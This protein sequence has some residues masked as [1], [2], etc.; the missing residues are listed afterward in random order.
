MPTP[1]H[2]DGRRLKVLVIGG[3]D[4]Q[5][6]IM[7]TIFRHLGHELIGDRGL[8][9]MHDGTMPGVNAGHISGMMA[10]ALFAE[11]RPDLVVLDL[12][13]PDS[14]GYDT[15]VALRRMEDPRWVPIWCLA[16]YGSRADNE[17][18]ALERGADVLLPRPIHLPLLK[19]HLAQVGRFLVR[20]GQFERRREYLQDY[21]ESAESEIK[22]ARN[23]MDR[24]LRTQTDYASVMQSWIAPAFKFSGDAMVAE[25]SPD[26]SLKLLLADGV[27]HGL[28][29]ALNVL[30]VCR[31]FQSMAQK[32]F[33]LAAMVVELNHTIRRDLPSH[34]FVAATLVNVNAN[35]GIIEVWNGGNPACF[36]IDALGDVAETWTSNHLPLGVVDSD[37]LDPRPEVRALET[38]GQLVLYSDGAIEALDESG[39]AFGEAALLQ[40]LAEAPPGVRLEA[41][42]F[43]VVEHLA[44]RAANDDVTLALLDCNAEFRQARTRR[45]E[46]EAAA[47]ATDRVATGAWEMSL[48]VESASLRW[49]DMAPVLQEFVGRIDPQWPQGD[50]GFTRLAELYTEALENGLLK[51]DAGLKM[52]PDGLAAYA[53]AREERLRALEAGAVRITLARGADQRLRLSLHE[54]ML[55]S[56]TAPLDALWEEEAAE[57]ELV[58]TTRRNVIDAA[59]GVSYPGHI[60]A[61][62]GMDVAAHVA[63]V[64]LQPLAPR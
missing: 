28:S 58:A 22:T 59:S 48:V 37:E 17:A 36:M 16:D 64:R 56:A 12:E 14:G 18:L 32:G 61:R 24:L 41:L 19:A 39:R 26:G 51:L 10:P 57:A 46:N 47:A 1:Q 29:A 20:Q 30:P 33:G 25:R 49:L 7:R 13:A 5:L 23:I 15:L 38:D 3:D 55:G 44:G 63:T 21:F 45:A 2:A 8:A 34:R 42:K 62:D 4:T 31:A 40:A 60:A 43:A 35:D 53:E 6:G 9:G 11:H 54:S 27:G 50:I 52:Q